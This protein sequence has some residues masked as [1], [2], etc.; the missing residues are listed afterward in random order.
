MCNVCRGTLGMASLGLPYRASFPLMPLD[1][2]LAKS[3]IVENDVVL[4]PYLHP[5]GVLADARLAA[6]KLTTTRLR[7]DL[8]A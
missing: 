4:A 3:A 1:V 7:A 2:R 5:C 8:P 6:S